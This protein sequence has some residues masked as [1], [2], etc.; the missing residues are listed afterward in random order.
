[1]T[2][3]HTLPA[4]HMYTLSLIPGHITSFTRT[5]C[6]WQGTHYQ[7]YRYTLSITQEHTLPVLQVHTHCQLVAQGLMQLIWGIKYT[8]SVTQVH[9]HC[10]LHRCTPCLF[11]QHMYHTFSAT[12]HSP[13]G[14]TFTWGICCGLYLWHKP[15]ELAHSFLFSSCVYFCLYGF[16][17]CISFH[18]FSRQLS[19]FSL[20]SPGLISAL[21]ALSTIYLFMKVSFSPDVI[22]CGWLGLKRQLTEHCDTM[23]ER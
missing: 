15:T 7:F 22:L 4:V 23:S 11:P 5:R 20:C 3:E 9:T 14:L 1:M 19:V 2:L 8:L 13:H 21:F 12:E 6:H 17:N 16:F 18:Q 10:Q